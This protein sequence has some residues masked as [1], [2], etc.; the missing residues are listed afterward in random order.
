MKGGPS[1]KVLIDL[2]IGEN[3]KNAQKAENVLKSQV[4][5]YESDMERL[6]TA[7]QNGNKIA[8]TLNI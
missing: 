1:V 3:L 2:A 8:N 4:F 5:L 6:K 7:Y